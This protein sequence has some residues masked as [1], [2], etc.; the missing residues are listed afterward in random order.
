ME[1]VA[2]WL[3]LELGSSR[4]MTKLNDK[5]LEWRKV[6]T[7]QRENIPSRNSRSRSAEMCNQQSV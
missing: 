1:N 6:T 7:G 2:L 3:G 5:D 4:T